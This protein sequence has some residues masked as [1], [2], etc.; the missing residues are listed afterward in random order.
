MSSHEPL[1]EIPVSRAGVEQRARFIANT[2]LHLLA[3]IGVFA[4]AE[5][6]LFASGLAEPIA[7]AM[8]RVNWLLILGAFVLASF[9]GSHLAHRAA[10]RQAQ[11]AGL[12]FVIVAEALIFVPLLWI[13][14]FYAPGA[15]RSAAVVTA[16]G[17]AA[18]TFIAF[19]TRRDFS[20]LRSLLLWGGTIA[21]VLI[22]AAVI[23]GLE[24]GTLFA[25]A[26]VAFAGVAIL[27]DTSNV[28][29]H[30]SEDRYVAAALELF[31]SIA[32]M[33]WYVLSIF[34]PRD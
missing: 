20:F 22:V 21:M 10:S 12:G 8:L 31:S 11:Y 2:Y 14:D 27:Y 13:A 6:L 4:L 15:I 34:I 5:L 3:A 33:F 25:I 24:L 28:L 30:F 32:L 18:L 26:M 7:L 29:H 17:F 19:R 23:W 1:T 9:G 16:I